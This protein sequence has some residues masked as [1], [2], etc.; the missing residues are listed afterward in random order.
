MFLTAFAGEVTLVREA[1]T[2]MELAFAD[3]RAGYPTRNLGMR[4]LDPEQSCVRKMRDGHCAMDKDHR[5]RC[6]TVVFQCE[7]CDK[8]RRGQPAGVHQVKLGDGTIDDEFPF[9]FM[10]VR[11]IA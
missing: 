9:C 4:V 8:T 11:N 1:V 10:C 5:G 6:S 7:G 2:H 3:G